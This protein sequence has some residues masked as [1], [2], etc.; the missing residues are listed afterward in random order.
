MGVKFLRDGA[1]SANFVSM[2]GVDGQESLDWFANDFTSIIPDAQSVFLKPLE[3]HFDT[4]TH[5]ITEMGMS[6][7]ASIDQKGTQ[8]TPVFPRMIRFKPTGQFH[9]PATKADGYTDWMQDIASIPS[10]SVLYD[11]YALDQPE[12][13]GGVETKIGQ[14]VTASEFTTSSWGD[15]HM[16]FRH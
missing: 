5:Y 2:Y 6:N 10:G 7:F 16:Y 13:M 14:L 12:E 15:E 4:A 3:A 1:D 11:I 9:F 8:V